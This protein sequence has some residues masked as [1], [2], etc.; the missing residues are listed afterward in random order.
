M[1]SLFLTAGELT[2]GDDDGGGQTKQEAAQQGNE[3]GDPQSDHAATERKLDRLLENDEKLKPTAGDKDAYASAVI[4]LANGEVAEVTVEPA[5]GWNL[6]VR[7][8]HFDRR[9]DHNYEIN[10]GGHVTSISHRAKYA[11]PRTVTQSDRVVATVSNESGDSSVIDFEMEAWAE[12]PASDE[13]K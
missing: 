1:A 13:V 10:V 4:E 9:D 8:V 2:G 11:S 6:R 12:R 3:A 5:S 7:E